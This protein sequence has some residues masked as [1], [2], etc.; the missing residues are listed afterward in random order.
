MR[1]L[2]F[3]RDA[4]RRA[5]GVVS[6]V[7]ILM[8]LVA[9]LD[10]LAVL[11]VVPLVD[12]ILQT[13]GGQAGRPGFTAWMLAVG[14]SPSVGAI[15]AI[16][17]GVHVVRAGIQVLA[18]YV[19]FRARSTLLRDLMRGTFQDCL[20]ARW[21]FFTSREQAT[22]LH[23]FLR[24]MIAVGDA[25]SGLV[26]IAA[27]TVQVVM[28]VVVPL[29][30]SWQ[31]TALSVTA[32]LLVAWPLAALGRF[33]Y[34]L[35]GRQVDAVGALASVFQQTFG[36]IKVV[37]AFG[38]QQHAVTRFDRAFDAYDRSVVRAGTLSHSISPVYYPLGLSVVVLTLLAARQ[39]QVPLSETA[40]VLYSLLRLFSIVGPLAVDK[41]LI[42]A[43]FAGY[44]RAL[45]LGRHARQARQPTGSRPF[46]TFQREIA[47]ESVSFAHP[48][49][50]P[51]LVGI[52][53][54]V[55]KGE[56]VAFVGE[57]G[58]GKST[59]V[60]LLTGLHAPDVGRVAIDGSSLSDFDV[61]SY[62]RRLGYVSQE[63]VL[64]NMSIRDN[65]RW[66]S[67]DATDEDVAAACRQANAV[68]FIEQLPDRYD[69]V[70]GDR[71]VRLSGGQVQRIAL[72]RAMV[73]KPDLLILDEATSALDSVSERLIQQ[74]IEAIARSTTVV[75]IA[76]R[77]S[78]ISNADHIYVLSQGR[79]VEH[80]S[81]AALLERDGA[82]TQMAGL[83][84]LE[85]PPA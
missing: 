59:L 33:S 71:G 77:L 85:A 6:V 13:S 80:G 23:L 64:F 47:F 27:G 65:I 56:F 31:L 49:R 9:A 43:F 36:A 53:A 18:A 73:R 32:G 3:L 12:L 20:H 54:Q 25:F 11:S 2:A 75:A 55:R 57:S 51:T 5:P 1:V 10:A 28:Y 79:I 41:H 35:G 34:R 58:A 60:D 84:S 83:Q 14:L 39:L 44:E 21:E 22:L 82:F 68:E 30:L 4:C 15:L 40:A 17:L 16:F 74:A 70:V 48:G 38:N 24:E 76:H 69:T 81:Y 19:T 37:L 46:E 45:E 26:R 42:D 8:T 63:P 72:A 50:Q 29:Y 66:A 78:T 61:A 52:N 67:E 7:G 62:R